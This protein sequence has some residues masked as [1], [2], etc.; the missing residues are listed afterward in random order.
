M[1]RALSF[2]CVVA[3]LMSIICFSAALAEGA[4]VTMNVKFDENM[5]FSRYDVDLYLDS[6]MIKTFKHG[7]NFSVS[8]DASEGSHTIWFYDHDDRSNSGSIPITVNSDMS[9]TCRIHCWNYQ[10]EISELKIVE[11]APSTRSLANEVTAA[12]PQETPVPTEPP[13]TETTEVETPPQSNSS[14]SGNGVWLDFGTATDEELEEALTKIK[15]EQRARLK[16]KIVINEETLSLAKGASAK[17]TAEVIDIPE[18]VKASKIVW[19]TS[20]KEIATCQNGSVAGKGN[21]N[22]TI[23]A[24]CTL[25]D[26]TEIS[27]ECIVTVY[28]PIKS[29]QTN[30]KKLNLGVGEIVDTDIVIQPN[31]ASNTTLEWS[32]T[33]DSVVSVNSEGTVTGIGPGSAVVSASSTD[34]S[35]KKVEIAVSVTKKDDR[36]KR[37]TNS[38]GISLTV[39]GFKQTRGS[40]YAQAEAGNTFVLIEMQIENNSSSD[41]TI[42]S[43]FGFDAICDDYSVDYSFSADMATNND[44]SINAV[45]PGR[46]VKGWKGFEVPQNWKELIVTFTPD[47]SVW[48]SG[49]KIEFVLY[50]N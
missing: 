46:K 40:G 47:A 49:D 42:N 10:V 3:L 43:T 17:L 35:D 9:I 21:G 36:G 15:A 37:I 20:S 38:D 45:K 12:P 22:A 39:L 41:L 31:D 28:T 27:G 7:Q 24:S 1:K 32:S 29:M 4:T 25:S 23:T 13:K 33:D 2:I 16:T 48:G 30:V 44:F 11:E 5:L 50:N 18:G 6:S 34:G 19:E 8:F 26:G 14:P